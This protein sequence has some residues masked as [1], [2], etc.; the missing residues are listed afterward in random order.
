VPF[1]VFALPFAG[2]AEWLA[3]V[4]PADDIGSFNSIP[5]NLFDVSYVWYVG[6]MLFQHSAGIRVY[7]TIPNDF[8]AGS[9]KPQIKSTNARK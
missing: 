7:F 1:V 6:P 2:L 5:I 9:L 8:H 4:S 3:G